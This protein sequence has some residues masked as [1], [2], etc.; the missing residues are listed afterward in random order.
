MKEWQRYTCDKSDA[1]ATFS[2][3]PEDA[4][5]FIAFRGTDSFRDFLIDACVVKREAPFLEDNCNDARVHGGFLEQY[6]SCRDD[7]AG[8]VD[9]FPNR[10][11]VVV[12]GHSLGGALATLFAA[13]LRDR[14]PDEN[15]TCITFG[16]PRVGNR[17]FS[18]HLDRVL[19]VKRIVVG[20]DPV[21]TIPTRF[22]WKHAGTRALFVNG[23]KA[24]R[25]GSGDPWINALLLPNLL[26]LS[27]HDMSG[28]ID[29]VTADEDDELGTED[30][31]RVSRV[32]S[33]VS[34]ALLA[35]AGAVVWGMWHR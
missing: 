15:V 18:Q 5:V 4:A 31:K 25:S 6:L 9:R 32:K 10:K 35:I 3:R 14:N 16:C 11:N 12:T 30:Y 21:T 8:Y 34:K 19:T 26:R 33:W 1:Q 24:S 17:A 13:Y 20:N 7:A 22:R 28:Y 27:D 29:A 23:E 2:Y